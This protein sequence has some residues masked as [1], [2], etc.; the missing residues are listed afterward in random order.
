[1]AV[2]LYSEEEISEPE[3]LSGHQRVEEKGRENSRRCDV[4]FFPKT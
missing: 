3:G 4:Y 1:M 2:F